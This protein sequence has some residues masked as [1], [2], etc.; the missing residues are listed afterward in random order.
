VC[1]CSY[2]TSIQAQCP[3]CSD[4]GLSLGAAEAQT[5]H[6]QAQGICLLRTRAALEQEQSLS[7]LFGCCPLRSTRKTKWLLRIRKN[8]WRTG[9][10][11]RGGVLWTLGSSSAFLGWT[12]PSVEGQ[13]A[14][15]GLYH[16]LSVNTGGN[17]WQIPELKTVMHNFLNSFMGQIFIFYFGLFTRL[18]KH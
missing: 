2:E 4:P 1:V 3:P 10:G 12:S 11:G 7:G 13:P 9:K 6:S 5:R 8:T 14:S 18:F 17:E 16:C 15:S